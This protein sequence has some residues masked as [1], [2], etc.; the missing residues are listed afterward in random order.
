MAV[1]AHHLRNWVLGVPPNWTIHVKGGKLYAS[2]PSG[3][4]IL[5]LDVGG[6]P[7]EEAPKVAVRSED[8]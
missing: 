6:E 1:E 3:S 4:I 8:K 5:S 2:S 7:G